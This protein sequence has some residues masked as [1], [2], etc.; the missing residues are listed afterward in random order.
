M[1][2]LTQ[3]MKKM[4]EGLAYAD[5]AEMQPMGD[6][7]RSLASDAPDSNPTAPNAEDSVE[8]ATTRRRIGLFVGPF[9][10]RHVFD[11][12]ADSCERLGAD[13][14]VLTFLGETEARVLI[15]SFTRVGSP[16]PHD[17]HIET[18][19]GDPERALRRVLGRGI[20][21]DF[22]VCDEQGYLGHH[23]LASETA[24]ELPVVMVATPRDPG[25]GGKPR[26]AP[27]DGALPAAG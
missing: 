22:L 4:L 5:L 12:A 26:N 19:S 6:K 9:A 17:V 15:E 7:Y 11:Y 21:I 18:L 3:A 24:A 20:R 14:V 8:P 25:P 10:P 13:L 27:A 2:A 1:P 16:L 23:V